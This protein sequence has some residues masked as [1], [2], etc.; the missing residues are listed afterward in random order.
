MIQCCS[1]FY[2]LELLV[3][4]NVKFR[5]LTSPEALFSLGFEKLPKKLDEY[6]DHDFHH[7]W[8][9]SYDFAELIS[10]SLRTLLKTFS[11]FFL[12]SSCF[13]M[14]RWMNQ[15]VA[16]LQMTSQL[17]FWTFWSESIQWGCLRTTFAELVDP[18]LSLWV[19]SIVSEETTW[20]SRPHSCLSKKQSS[21]NV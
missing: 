21:S 11:S 12:F 8:I 13:S 19:Y 10:D 5:I 4:L 9:I 18:L 20:W 15:S 1:I 6:L 14:T 2:S 3:S 7:Y 17:F 16:H